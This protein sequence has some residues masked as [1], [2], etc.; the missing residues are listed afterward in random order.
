MLPARPGPGI[1]LAHHRTR[2]RGMGNLE[3]ISRQ[4]GR[5][6]AA[7]ENARGAARLKWL[8]RAHL[9]LLLADEMIVESA[10]DEAPA[11]AGSPPDQDIPSP[12]DQ[13]TADHEVAIEATDGVSSAQSIRHLL[14]LLE[15]DGA[16]S[17]ERHS[18]HGLQTVLILRY[19]SGPAKPG[20]S[21]RIRGPVA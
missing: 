1:P 20:V 12:K 3:E 14:Q 17:A 15:A 5:A 16:G 8:R 4:L 10:L 6:F 11:K 2:M 19:C 21:A 13:L 18:C 9:L 7:L